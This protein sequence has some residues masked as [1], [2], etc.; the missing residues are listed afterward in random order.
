M[1]YSADRPD[2]AS[3]DLMV[4]CSSFP[5]FVWELME[6]VYP[7]RLLAAS[8]DVESIRA[9]ARLVT[10]PGCKHVHDGWCTAASAKHPGVDC[11]CYR[12]DAQ[13]WATRTEP[14]Q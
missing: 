10:C 14:T 1:E 11:N 2:I 3:P 12:P 9:V 13:K 6:R 7:N 8:R 5:P 4:R